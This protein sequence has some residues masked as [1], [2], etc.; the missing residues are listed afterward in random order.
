M[1]HA[2]ADDAELV[3]TE[4]LLGRLSSVGLVERKR[5]LAVEDEINFF[6]RLG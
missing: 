4:P 2:L 5:D 1:A 3:G 6:E